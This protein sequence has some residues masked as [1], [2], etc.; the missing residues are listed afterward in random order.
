MSLKSGGEDLTSKYTFDPHFGFAS[1]STIPPDFT[2]ITCYLA[3]LSKT[4]SLQFMVH[5][6]QQLV[7]SRSATI[8]VTLQTGEEVVETKSVK[9]IFKIEI[10]RWWRGG[11]T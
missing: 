3:Y 11:G 4:E 8:P 6:S 10:D 7:A 2:S 9:K 1:S 5:N